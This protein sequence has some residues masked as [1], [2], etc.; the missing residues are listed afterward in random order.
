[1]VI[2]KSNHYNL[3][4]CFNWKVYKKH[5][6]NLNS[7]HGRRFLVK[8]V[9]KLIHAMHM[10]GRGSSTCLCEVW[11]SSLTP[12]PSVFQPAFLFVPLIRRHVLVPRGCL[13]KRL[14]N[15]TSRWQENAA[16]PLPAPLCAGILEHVLVS[17]VFRARSNG[18]VVFLIF[19]AFCYHQILFFYQSL[20]L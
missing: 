2:D 6:I 14:Q 12:F 1:M 18:Q 4:I 7:K 19:L 9:Q 16:P 11:R 3:Y 8:H 5:F 17:I 13:H 10:G 20:E 15:E